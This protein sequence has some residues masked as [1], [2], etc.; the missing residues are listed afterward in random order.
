[1]RY[2]F[3]VLEGLDGVGKSSVALQLCRLL[4][5]AYLKTPVAPLS[6]IRAHIRGGNRAALHF[7]LCGLYLAAEQIQQQRQ[8]T[9]VVCDRWLYSTLAYQCPEAEW[10]A[11]DPCA[12]YPELPRPDLSIWLTASEAQRAIRLNQRQGNVANDYDLAL[13]ARATRAFQRFQLLSIDTTQLS[14]EQTAEHI[15]DQLR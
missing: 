6:H 5:A 13:Q 15:A 10:P 11:G 1:M 14:I 2:P 8:T 3:V 12:L 7:Y 9:P 4:G